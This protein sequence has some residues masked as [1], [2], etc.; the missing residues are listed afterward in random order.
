[1]RYLADG[2]AGPGAASSTWTASAPRVRVFEIGP[3]VPARRLGAGQRDT[4]DHRH[5]AADAAVRPGLGPAPTQ[6]QLG[7]QKAA[8]V[9]FFD[10]KGDLEALFA[11]RV[12]TL[13]GRQ[14]SGA[15]SGP[16]RPACCWTARRSASSAR[17]HPKWRQ[18]LRAARS[19]PVLFELDLDAVLARTRP[20]PVAE[21]VPTPAGGRSAIW[22]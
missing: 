4:T 22:R 14:A 18:K 8:R 7:R 16:H 15:A 21:P 20:Q 13:R 12:L 11:P 6:Q 3:R 19:A 17:L 9:D 1:M 5:R 10:V 2:L